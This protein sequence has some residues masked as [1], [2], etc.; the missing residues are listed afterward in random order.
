MV[1]LGPFARRV[2]I[3]RAWRG[4]AI[5]ACFGALVA[6]GWSGLDWMGRADASP[7]GMAMCVGVSSLIGAVAGACLRLP[8]KALRAS[9]DRRAR[10]DN[11]LTASAVDVPF[12]EE[13]RADAQARL[14]TVRPSELYPLG[15]G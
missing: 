13:I 1:E 8:V 4:A 9:V 3:V 14:S 6:A 5:G 7:A 10:L 11:R 2:R 12:V 15:V